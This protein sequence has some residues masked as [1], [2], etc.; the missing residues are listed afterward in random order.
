[1]LAMG[2]NENEGRL[3]KCVACES[4]TSKLAP[5]RERGCFQ[6]P[7]TQK[8]AF[9]GFCEIQGYDLEFELVPR[10]RL[11]LPRP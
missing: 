8:P 3:E 5:T 10:R 4:I 9:A 1:M 2:V 11:E 6:M 7:E